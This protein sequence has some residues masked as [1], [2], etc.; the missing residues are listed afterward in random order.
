M[1]ERDIRLLLV[2]D[3]A[4]TRAG[5]RRLLTL[6]LGVQVVGEAENGEEAVKK[7]KILH[8]DVVLMDINMPVMDGITATEKI[9]SEHP[10]TVIIVISVQGENEYLRKAM[11][12]GAKD[13]LVKPFGADELVDCIKKT[14]EREANRR[15]NAPS[16][17]SLML[18]KKQGKVIAVFGPKGGVGK[19]TL[20]VNLAAVLVNERKLRTCLVDLSLQFG[21]VCVMLSLV[22]RRTLSDLVSEN[23]IDKD[24]IQPYLLHH[25][26]GVKVL[27]APLSPEYAEYITPEHVSRALAALR[28]MFDYVVID[29]PSS[30]ADISLAA[31]DSSDRIIVIGNMDMAALK[32]MKLALEVMKRLNY[33][34]DKIFTIMN[35]A[36]YDLGIKFKDLE[37]ALGR[38]INFFI[39]NDEGVAV[40]ALNRGMP[41]V[42]D[43]ADAKLSRRIFDLVNEHLEPKTM[44]K[45][46]VA[47]FWQRRKAK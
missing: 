14:W 28:D 7:V 38:S 3:S 13:Y 23:A 4:D 22:P 11:I 18:E 44:E 47:S 6:S 41:F 20:A 9:I 21:D 25:P 17:S 30:F 42:L 35:R 1:P 29:M 40:T 19:T 31:L 15:R 33:S 24:T 45:E 5:I 26:C 32:N 16:M 27:P 8:P 46:N 12:S 39:Q 37:P 43:Q 2:D 34:P 10:D 36:G